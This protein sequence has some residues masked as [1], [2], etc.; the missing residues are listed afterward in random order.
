M[1]SM[2]I[3]SYFIKNVTIQFSFENETEL[4]QKSFS[5]NQIRFVEKLE[6]LN[7]FCFDS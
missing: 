2:S 4:Q 7:P 1:D 5:T 3:N 6:L